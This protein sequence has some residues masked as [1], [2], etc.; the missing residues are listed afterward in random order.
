MPY[1][2]RDDNGKVKGCYANVQPEYAEEWLDADDPEV[3][4]FNLLISEF[5]SGLS[6]ESEPKDSLSVAS[7]DA[8]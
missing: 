4:A 1:V 3:A 2:E 7:G 5:L 8:E 6:V